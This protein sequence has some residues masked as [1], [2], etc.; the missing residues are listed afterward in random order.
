M[1]VAAIKLVAVL[2]AMSGESSAATAAAPSQ[3]RSVRDEECLVCHESQ[4]TYLQTAHH[5]TSRLPSS[6]SVRGHFSSGV[7]TLRTSNPELL[8]LM[9]ST[10][11]G[12]Y[13]NAVE[14]VPPNTIS[15]KE[16]IDLVVGSGRKGQTYLYWNGNRLYELPVSYWTE[17]DQWVTSPGYP[18]NVAEF[19]R[20]VPPRCLECHA[21]YFK[22]LSFA[23][24]GNSYD[25]S[26]FELG[27]SCERCHGPG[28]EHVQFH[29]AKVHKSTPDPIV[30]PA[31]L[32]RERQLDTCAIC[33]GGIGVVPLAPAFSYVPGANLERYIELG[34]PD[35]DAPI[36][37]HGNQVALLA[38]SRCFQASL[39]T[40]TTCH[41]V[42]AAQRDAAAFSHR[43]LNCHKPESCG[44]YPK[45]GPQIA[46][47]CV[48][49][50]MPRQ[51][52]NAI[53]SG[54]NGVRVRPLVRTHWIK[55]YPN[56]SL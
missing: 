13:E 29:R 26:E 17:L 2:V 22:S 42:H 53:V 9:D 44:M 49:C 21:S 38:R 6:Q 48:D 36:D 10:V 47:D 16:R 46:N 19:N 3:T 33:H 30:N 27:I 32:S 37:V 51:E 56:Q 23:P 55:I 31:K 1:I 4:A 5:L 28:R 45:T 20:P 40:C 12:L 14:G 50:H 34:R 52:S 8:Y 11:N 54:A 18:D 43:C 41:D 24:P 25:K 35:P 7:N 39:M 15:R